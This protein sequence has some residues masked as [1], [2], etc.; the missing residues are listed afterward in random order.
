MA[1]LTPGYKGH[2]FVFVR[3]QLRALAE[4]AALGKLSPAAYCEA[5][6]AVCKST[7]PASALE[8]ELIAA[9]ALRQPLAQLIQEIP[10]TY[11]RWLVV[12]Y[13]QAWY[14]QLSDRAQIDALFG[15]NHLIFI[16]QLE[17]LSLLPDVFY[18]L[19]QKATRP[20]SECI[21]IDGDANR[22]VQSMKHG[23]TSVFYV[24]V[25]RLKLELALQE[26]WQTNVD[27][28]HPT[29]SERVKL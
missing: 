20:M 25:Q 14:E 27:V 19:P 10:A 6:L 17:L 8:Q 16:E 4:E 24:Y 22:A 23:L 9:A 3:Q 12:D 15:G 11:E 26:I 7:M 2:D 13:P 1:L 28:M 29:S 18:R 5:S 21:I